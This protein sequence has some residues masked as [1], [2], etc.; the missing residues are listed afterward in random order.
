MLAEERWAKATFGDAVLGDRRRVDRLVSV[1]ARAAAQPTGT[2]TGVLKTSAEQEGAFRL[3]E[4]EDVGAAAI[5]R[6]AFD[7]TARACPRDALIYVPIDGSSLTL[8]DL[9]RRREL[10]RVGSKP[11]TRGLEVMT[12]LAV[13]EHG[14]PTGVL[15]QRWW[16]RE[17]EPRRRDKYQSQCI[18]NR[19]LERETRF[20]LETL[21]TCEDRLAD[22]AQQSKAWYQ[23]DRG[24]DCWPVFQHALDHELLITIRSN[25]NRRLV[26]PDGP[27][28]E[29]RYLRQELERQRSM[30]SYEI[31][32]PRR[33]LR[34]RRR[35]AITLRWCKVQISARISS[36]HRK[37][38]EFNAVLARESQ[39]RP[40]R[41]S[42][43]LL[44]T[45][46]IESRDDVEAVVRGYTLR[47]RIEDF[48]RAWKRGHCN[49]EKTQLQGRS[50]I[51]KWATILAA[52]AARALHLAHVLR[53]AP[54]LPASTEFTEYEIE[55]SFIL[56]EK[57]RDQRKSLSVGDVLRLIAELG[58]FGNRYYGGKLPG[59]TVIG[60][61]LTYLAPLARGLEI[62]DKMR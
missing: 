46:A 33:G 23:L 15:D 32:V 9:A 36:N 13:N 4:N 8:T 25:H 48:H 28:G 57:K 12:A 61:G 2:V 20:W 42:W 11:K 16:A 53:S 43:V 39:R 14:C 31:E 37:I 50:T 3:L 26:G 19:H 59:A 18:N 47:W 49:V 24:A 55:A 62:Q 22:N 17:H 5:Q 51:I 52:V 58:G 29:R 41:I 45:R 54:D 38:F 10:G 56:N 34:G 60:R 30:G 35:A 21:T 44:T 27:K 1:A 40:D 7:A 6:A